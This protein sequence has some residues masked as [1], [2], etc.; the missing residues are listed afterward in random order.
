MA[1]SIT[2]V[3][4]RDKLKTQ[5]EPHWLKVSTG[6]YIGFRKIT[7]TSTGTWVAR[8]YDQTTRKQTKHA[9]G[10]FDDVLPARRY[11]AARKAAQDWFDHIAKGGTPTGSTISEVCANYVKHL[12][13]RKGDTAAD[14]VERRFKAYVLDDAAFASTDVSKLTP[15]LVGKWLD[16]LRERKTTSG[17]NRGET[18]TDSSLNRDV[19]PFRAAL[20]LAHDDGL[21]TS[22]FAWRVKLRPIPAA[23]RRRDLYLDRDQRRKFIEKAAPDVALLL[24]GLSLV[25]L[26]PGA[27]A[28]LTVADFNKRLGVLRIPDDKAGAGRGIKL[29]Q[30]TAAFFAEAIKDKLPTAPLLARAD[31]VAW[32][33]DSWKGPVKDAVTVAKLPAETT[34]YTMRHSVITDLVHAGADLLTVAQVAGTSVRMIEAHYGHLRDNVVVAALDGLAL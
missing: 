3:A 11:D 19:T 17:G 7:P 33:K 10:A 21:V 2:T 14:D 26:R 4:A 20:N 13:K 6:C 28:A 15:L 9:L 27:L 12:R 24:K 34:L 31:G 1:T 16:R 18:R 30:T 25:P 23:D 8:A 32:N 29:P 22:D 5:H